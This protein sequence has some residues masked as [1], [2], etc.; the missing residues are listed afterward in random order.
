MKNCLQKPWKSGFS[1]SFQAQSGGRERHLHV[2]L[3]EPHRL[4]QELLPT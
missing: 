2:P 3:V 1:R 4:R